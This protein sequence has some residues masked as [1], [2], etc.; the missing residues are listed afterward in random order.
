MAQF[1]TK[2]GFPHSTTTIEIDFVTD[3]SA[4]VS[5]L[6]PRGLPQFSKGENSLVN[7]HQ[8]GQLVPS[9][10]DGLRSWCY[11]A[12]DYSVDSPR[13]NKFLA[14]NDGNMGE[15]KEIAFRFQGFV[16]DVQLGPYGT[17]SG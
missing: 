17:W 3:G 2:G 14:Y 1:T 10:E 4:L 9:H 6:W 15:P 8:L 12:L 16:R 13:L 5:T 7:V 11:V